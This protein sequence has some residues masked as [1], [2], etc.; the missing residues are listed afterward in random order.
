MSEMN[1]ISKLKKRKEFLIVSKKGKYINCKDF[2]IQFYKR[3][4]SEENTLGLVRYG[5]TASKKV[6]NAVSRNR[7]KRRIR[8]IIRELLPKLAARDFDYVVV[9][10]N[11]LNKANIFDLKKELIKTLKNIY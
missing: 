4:N 3:S 9:A 8:V 1:V 10:K 6:G 11:S 2:V 7:A 5:I